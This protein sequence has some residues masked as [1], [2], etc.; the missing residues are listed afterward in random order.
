MNNN[1][2]L[3]THSISLSLSKCHWTLKKIYTYIKSIAFSPS[4]SLVIGGVTPTGWCQRLI[5]SQAEEVGG[6]KK[7]K[8]CFSL[9][10]ERFDIVEIKASHSQTDR[11]HRT[12]KRLWILC[13]S[14]GWVVVTGL[15]VAAETCP[16]FTEPVI[17]Q[18]EQCRALKYEA[19]S[20]FSLLKTKLNKWDFSSRCSPVNRSSPCFVFS[21][22]PSY[23]RKTTT[24]DGRRFELSLYSCLNTTWEELCCCSWSSPACIHWA[25]KNLQGYH[26]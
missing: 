18:L 4:P 21:F 20:A 7:K 12:R 11:G 5:V 26:S 9:V 23:S 14:G 1:L 13:Q 10:C 19:G 8:K 17:I 24:V 25:V 15:A 3:K 22:L 6:E 2:S 16:S